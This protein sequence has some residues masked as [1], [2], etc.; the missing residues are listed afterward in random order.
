ML[1]AIVPYAYPFKGTGKWH[2]N[3]SDCLWVLKFLFNKVSEKEMAN[4]TAAISESK[5]NGDVCKKDI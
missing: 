3:P 4:A 2:W 5:E 1:L